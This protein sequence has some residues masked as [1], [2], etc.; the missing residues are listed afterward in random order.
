MNPNARIESL[1]RELAARHAVS[2]DA[3]MSLLQSLVRTGGAS[4]QFNHPEL[5]RSGQWLAGGMTQIGYIFNNA[6]R[7]K[8]DAL[9]MA[10]APVAGEYRATPAVRSSQSQSQC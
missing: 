9:C 6:L 1:I 5:G 10:L 2:A 8:V 7:A 3:V 4:A